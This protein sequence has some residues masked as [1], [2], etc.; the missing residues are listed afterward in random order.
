ME[1]A[2]LLVGCYRA[3]EIS[4]PEVFITGVAA[5][6]TD[7]PEDVVRRVTDPRRGIASRQKFVPNL[8]ECKEAC[9]DEMR[10]IRREEARRAQ[11]A[12]SAT[13]L[14]A[15]SVPKPDIEELKRRHGE[16]WGIDR[17]PDRPDRPKPRTLEE[18]AAAKEEPIEISEALRKNLIERALAP[19]TEYDR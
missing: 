11:M 10:P 14:A 17:H 12:Q 1:R 4:N 8:A 9:E 7:Y 6:F 19:R 15:P 5:V 2:G 16:T 18:L 3:I 13:M